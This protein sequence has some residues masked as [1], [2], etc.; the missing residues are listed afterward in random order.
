[1]AAL[2]CWIFR[3]LCFK[4]LG[5]EPIIMS[6]GLQLL[7]KLYCSTDQIALFPPFTQAVLQEAGCGANHHELAFIVHADMRVLISC[8]FSQALLQEAGCGA[9]HHERGEQPLIEPCCS[10]DRIALFPPFT[11]AVLQEAGPGANH[12]ERG[13]AGARVG[14]HPRQDDPRAL[15]VSTTAQM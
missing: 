10:N 13:R 8:T 11:Q 5:V 12:H 2:L 4:K 3:R 6:A 9:N 15:P 7:I 14:G 1:M